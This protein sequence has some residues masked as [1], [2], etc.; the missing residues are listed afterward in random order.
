MFFI[1]AKKI[2]KIPQGFLCVWAR[3]KDVNYIRQM[4]L[5][6]FSGVGVNPFNPASVRSEGG[7]GGNPAM[8]MRMSA[9][10]GWCRAKLLSA[11][12]RSFT[13]PCRTVK[14]SRRQ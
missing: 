13:S 7:G 1:L 3:I 9:K 5:A 6:M 4:F 2:V 12:L 14:D 8:L 10:G 11:F